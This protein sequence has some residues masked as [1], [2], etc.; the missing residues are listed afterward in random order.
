MSTNG[1]TSFTAAATGLP[2]VASWQLWASN[3]HPTYGVEGDVWLTNQ[4]GGLYRSTNSAGSFTKITNVQEAT[5]VGFGKAKDGNTYPAVYLV[6]KVN[7]QMGFFRSDDAGATWGR[8][9]DDQHPFGGIND[10]TGDTWPRPG[11]A[12]STAI[13]PVLSMA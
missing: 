8:I 7:N 5:K 3:I 13:F 6:G 2:T 12:S 10:I 9:T 4:N 11:G 1:G